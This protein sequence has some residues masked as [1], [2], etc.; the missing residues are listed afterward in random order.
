MIPLYRGF[1]NERANPL[2]DIAAYHE[3]GHA[4]MAIQMGAQVRSITI[5]PD[6]DDGP[7][8]YADAQIAWPIDDF[9]QRELHE[10]MVLVALAGPVAEMLYRGEPLHPGFVA[11]WAADWKLAWE[12]ATPLVA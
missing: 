12:A 4:L 11:E 8:R 3:S 6:W 9:S 2:S 10:K 7:E 5:Q 1:I